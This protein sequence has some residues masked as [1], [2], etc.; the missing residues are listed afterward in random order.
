MDQW[1]RKFLGEEIRQE[2]LIEAPRR[3][4]KNAGDHISP[5]GAIT[6][7]RDPWNLDLLF[8]RRRLARANVSE[9]FSGDALVFLGLIVKK[10]PQDHPDKPGG[11]GD[12]KSRFPSEVLVDPGYRDG[13]Q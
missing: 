9:L 12:I 4:C 8:L 2:G 10:P 3:R 7:Q 5:Y 6:Q 13:T 1:R 11:A